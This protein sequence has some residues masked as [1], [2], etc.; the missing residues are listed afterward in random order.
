MVKSL[1]EVLPY[2]ED[3]YLTF[4]LRLS[5]LIHDLSYFYIPH[6]QWKEPG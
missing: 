1:I 5:L 2:V 4:F 6:G 3:I